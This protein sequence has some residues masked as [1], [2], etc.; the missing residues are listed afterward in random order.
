MQKQAPTFG[1]ISAMIIFTLG[2][3]GILLYLWLTFGGPVQLQPERYRVK[4]QFDESPLLVDEADV[5]ISGLNVGKV[6]KKTL[7]RDGGQL[8]EME[9]DPKYGPIPADT[10]ATLRAKSLLGQIY[11]ELA[12]GDKSGEMLK[13]GETLENTQV[14]ESVEVDEIVGVFDEETRSHYRGWIRELAKGLA[15]GRGEHLND[16]I[17]NLPAFAV[18]GATVLRT[19]DEQSPA[20]RRLV[21]NAGIALRAVNER[22]GQLRGLVVNAN[23][24]F[25][26]V[27]SRDDALAETIFV[28]PT[29][30]E[31]SRLT[32][33]RLQRF[34]TDTRPLVRA[35][36]PVARKLKP[37]IHD[38]GKLAPNL[39]SLF[40]KMD[41]LIDE[42]DENLGDAVRFLNGVSPVFSAL[43]VYL[44]ELNPI[45][46][47]LN[48]QQEQVADFIT[49]GAGSLNATLPA[50]P[51]EGPR[52]YL[53]QYAMITSRSTGIHQTRPEWDRGN[54]YPL[55]NYLKRN[56]PLGIT[57]AF[58]CKASGGPKPEATNGSPPCF[59]QPQHLWDGNQFP[60][61][62][63]GQRGKS[64]P[65]GN[66]G[67][68]PPG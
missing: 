24:F 1:R 67:T 11:V 25:G 16:A 9:L 46:S 8:V 10:R 53:R 28:F 45:I 44:P 54:S 20:L 51:G 21:R 32:L 36:T 17:G 43:H 62:R 58:D 2:C 4:A 63:K 23:N 5:R 68:R 59:V 65:E 61:V 50:L 12:P 64:K 19:L 34:S 33:D 13:E 39:Q 31:E 38:V 7:Q 18:D 41:P 22:E 6:K 49:N 55:P 56:R 52:H 66:D 15:N 57:E 3:V 26:A 40:R 35:L 37:T 14:Q 27:A 47:Y 42:S 48:Y 30:L 60:R 29:F